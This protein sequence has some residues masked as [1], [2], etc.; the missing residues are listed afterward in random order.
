MLDGLRRE[1]RRSS[2][3]SR[4][5]SEGGQRSSPAGRRFA[6]GGEQVSQEGRVNSYTSGHDS[7][8]SRARLGGE[9]EGNTITPAE[10]AARIVG[11]MQ[12]AWNKQ[13]RC[14]V[15]IRAGGG[16]VFARG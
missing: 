2:I 3:G 4:R 11:T 6:A 1:V 5:S 13:K 7:E 14:D 16:A 12:S 9:D 10:G 15:L 8:K